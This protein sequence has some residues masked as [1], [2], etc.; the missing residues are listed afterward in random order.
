MSAGSA[1]DETRFRVAGRLHWVHCARPG[2]YT[3][4]MVHPAPGR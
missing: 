3:L 4:F 2:K 1:F